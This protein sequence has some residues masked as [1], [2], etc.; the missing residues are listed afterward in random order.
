MHG[1]LL[2]S[3]QAALVFEEYLRSI[4]DAVSLE[5]SSDFFGILNFQES[6]NFIVKFSIS[7]SL[8]MVAFYGPSK[9]LWF[10]KIL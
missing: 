10:L 2:W 1:G 6:S 9:L 3:F 5:F 7:G 8:C 4:A